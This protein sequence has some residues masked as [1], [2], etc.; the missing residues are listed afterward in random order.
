[1]LIVVVIPLFS[2]KMAL[3]LH[4]FVPLLPHH[5]K[6]PSLSLRTHL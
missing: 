3:L 5:D 6:E 2:Y 4:A 1:M